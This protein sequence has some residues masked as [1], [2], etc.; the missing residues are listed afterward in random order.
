MLAHVYGPRKTAL[1]TPSAGQPWG[2]RRS[3]RAV[4][5]RAGRGGRDELT[6]ALKH[7]QLPRAHCTASGNLLYGSGSSNLVLCDKLEGW[8]GVGDGREVQE[9]G[10]ICVPV[11][12]SYRYIEIICFFFLIILYW[13]WEFSVYSLGLILYKIGDLE[14]VLPFCG[15]PS[16]FLDDVLWCTKIL[17]LVKSSLLFYSFVA[18][19]FNVYPRN[20]CKVPCQEDLLLFPSKLCGLT[21]CSWV[22]GPLC[23]RFVDYAR[24]RFSFLLLR[25][26]Y[27]VVPA[28]SVEKTVL[29]P[30]NGLG[31]LVKSCLIL[32]ERE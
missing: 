5:T 26:E 10:N 15:L 17:I 2:R 20:H 7:R 28:P 31:T 8:E 16:H 27:Q 9:G 24:H 29:S 18:Y 4:W 12:N 11:D 6:E 25:G 13:G 19:A 23:S 30:V 32:H 22:F 1:L 21:S 3:R 14:V